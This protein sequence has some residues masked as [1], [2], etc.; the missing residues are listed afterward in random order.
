[1]KVAPYT[2]VVDYLK[3]VYPLQPTMVQI[4][5]GLGREKKWVSNQLYR[6]KSLGIADVKGRANVAVWRLANQR[7]TEVQLSG[8]VHEGIH[9]V[10]YAIL[11]AMQAI[12]KERLLNGCFP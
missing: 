8:E 9:S 10:A 3:L 6:M 5:V 4:A 11:A 1:M 7:Y 2:P 12:T